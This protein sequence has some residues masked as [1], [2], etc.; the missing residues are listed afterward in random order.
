MVEASL[1]MSTTSQIPIQEPI[2]EGGDEGK[3]VILSE[4][5]ELIT[6][7]FD[8]FVQNVARHVSIINAQPKE[9]AT[10]I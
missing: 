2:R 10:A 6:N 4:N 8:T 5:N 1:Q 3:P 7:A 9:T